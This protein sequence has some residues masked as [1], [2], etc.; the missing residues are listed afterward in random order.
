MTRASIC[1][2]S[3][4]AVNDTVGGASVMPRMTPV[5]ATGK[6]PFGTTT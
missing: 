3:A 1:W 5:S 6:K 4:I 2:R